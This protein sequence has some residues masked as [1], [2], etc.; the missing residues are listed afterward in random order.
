MDMTI[1]TRIGL[2][3]RE[4]GLKQ[5][6]LAQRMGVSPQA[7]SKWE[8]DLNCP[9]ISLLPLLAQTLGVTVDHLLSGEKKETAVKLVPETERKDFQDMFLRITVDSV[10]GDKVRMNLPMSLVKVALDSGVEISGN[11]AIKQID[12]QQIFTLVSHGVVGDLIE[13]VSADGDIV[14]VFVE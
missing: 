5:E 7:V 8:N 11:S 3:R 9:D 14:R 6:E 12:L 1:G 2:L 13:V 4:K 10:D